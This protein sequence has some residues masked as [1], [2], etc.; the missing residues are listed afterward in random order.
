MHY[1][2][3]SPLGDSLTC[4]DIYGKTVT[5]PLEKMIFRNSVY[6]LIVHEDQLLVVRTHST[7]LW[8]FPGGGIEL[9]EPITEALAREVREETGICVKMGELARVEEDFFYYNPADEAYHAYLFFYWCEALST[10]LVSDT[11][12]FDEE[13]EM[14]RW[15]PLAELEPEDFQIIMRDAFGLVQESLRV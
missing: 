13:S 1:E 12:V 10:S 11:D 6:G 15:V 14:P 7:G 5:I 4:R 9:G 8:A 3:G 2:N